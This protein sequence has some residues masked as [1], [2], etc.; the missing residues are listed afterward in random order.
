MMGYSRIQIRYIVGYIYSYKKKNVIICIIYKNKA[1]LWRI[2]LGYAGF[3]MVG[4]GG[5]WWDMVKKMVG[6]G[7]ILWGCDGI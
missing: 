4:G 7:R 5:I 3:D 6:N 1:P 2:S